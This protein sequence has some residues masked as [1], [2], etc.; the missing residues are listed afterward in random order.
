MSHCCNDRVQGALDLVDFHVHEY[1]VILKEKDETIRGL[2]AR[3]ARLEP[4]PVSL[5]PAHPQRHAEQ[6]T[7]GEMVATFQRFKT[8]VDEVVEPFR[9]INEAPRV[10]LASLLGEFPK[11]YAGPVGAGERP[12][13]ALSVQRKEVMNHAK[14]RPEVSDI[15]HLPGQL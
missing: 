7:L 6:M 2:E 4:R 3:I 5:Q 14:H 15:R 9:R 8:V 12:Y 10:L 13:S 11:R 1:E